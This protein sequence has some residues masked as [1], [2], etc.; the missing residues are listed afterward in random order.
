MFF[1]SRANFFTGNK[2]LIT[3]DVM[4]IIVADIVVTPNSDVVIDEN[5]EMEKLLKTTVR[6]RGIHSISDVDIKI[7]SSTS[8]VASS[9]IYQ[10]ED[11]N[12]KLQN[13]NFDNI[14]YDQNIKASVAHGFVE[15][16]QNFTLNPWFDFYGDVHFNATKDFLRF[17][18][19]GKLIHT[20]SSTPPTGR[21]FRRNWP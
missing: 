10:Y 5:G 15:Q 8:Y 13:I 4:R 1:G 9:G 3:K 16:F 14:T 19:Y 18:G 12:K 20:C 17:E 11:M 2:K 21:N 6:A 7:N